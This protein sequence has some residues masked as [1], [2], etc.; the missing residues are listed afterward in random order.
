LSERPTLKRVGSVFPR[1]K[2]RRTESIHYSLLFP[3][4]TFP[5]PFLH[6][7]LPGFFDR[8]LYLHKYPFIPQ[9]LLHYLTHFLSFYLIPLQYISQTYEVEHKLQTNLWG[10]A[11]GGKGSGDGE[12][13]DTKRVHENKG[14]W[15]RRRAAENNGAGELPEAPTLCSAFEGGGGR[16]RLYTQGHHNYPL[17]TRPV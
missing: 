1:L 17:S 2:L 8:S 13:R 10:W 4:A 5:L 7:F 16:V 3:A 12:K 11:A 6:C 14:G 9:Y 15:W